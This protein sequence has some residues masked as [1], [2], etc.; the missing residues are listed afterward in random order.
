MVAIIGTAIR[1]DDAP[2]NQPQNSGEYHQEATE[3]QAPMRRGSI[4]NPEHN[5]NERHADHHPDRW[6]GVS[7]FKMAT[8]SG[9]GGDRCP[10]V[11]NKLSMNASAPQSTA[12]STCKIARQQVHQHAGDHAEQGLGPQQILHLAG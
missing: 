7:N 8:R 2:Y 11:W 3:V 10:H 1:P 6:H 5:V 9:D 12:K 4:Q